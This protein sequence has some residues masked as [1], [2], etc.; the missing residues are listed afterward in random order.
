MASVAGATPVVV[1]APDPVWAE[2]KGQ[3]IERQRAQFS[4]YLSDL[5]AQLPPGAHVDIV[6]EV[7]SDAADT[8]IACAK[9]RGA[10]VIVMA[11]RSRTGLAHA[12]F[13]STR[14]GRA[15][16]RAGALVPGRRDGETADFVISVVLPTAM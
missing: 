4:D 3:A 12:L 16:G 7:S 10:D 11:T 2:N 9:D 1:D 13:G 6:T 14:E 15:S 8:I 5:A